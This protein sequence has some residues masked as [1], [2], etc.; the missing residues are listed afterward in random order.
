MSEY[1]QQGS[2]TNIADEIKI[3]YWERTISGSEQLVLLTKA[4]QKGERERERKKKK[5][6]RSIFPI[7]PIFKYSLDCTNL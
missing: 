3:I 7:R 4:Q 1:V 2:S 5:E 6:K